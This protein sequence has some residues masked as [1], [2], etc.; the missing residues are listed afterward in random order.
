MWQGGGGGSEM[1]FGREAMAKV[2][3]GA[4]QPWSTAEAATWALGS[5]EA[6]AGMRVRV[7][8]VLGWAGYRVR[9]LVSRG[10]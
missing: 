6:L 7:P 4:Q 1:V 2:F 3:L 8:T 5:A 10:S 9:V